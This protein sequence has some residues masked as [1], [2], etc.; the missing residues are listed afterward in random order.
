MNFKDIYNEIIR[1]IITLIVTAGFDCIIKEIKRH[2]SK[3]KIVI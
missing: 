3:K 2:L 1:I